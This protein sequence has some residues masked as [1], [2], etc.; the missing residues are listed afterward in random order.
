M[1]SYTQS[2]YQPALR[3]PQGAHAAVGY[4]EL[5][6]PTL[7]WTNGATLVTGG[8][9]A[10][11]PTDYTTPPE[12]T[13]DA[14]SRM[15][16]SSPVTVFDS[17]FQYGLAPLLYEQAL[18]GTASIT[19]NPTNS[20]AVLSGTTGG[21]ASA[22]LQSYRYVR[23]QPAKSHLA[24]ITFVL[25][26]ATAS[27]TKRVGLWDGSNGFYLEQ[28]GDGT[29]SLTRASTSSV[30]NQTVAQAS[31]NLDPLNGNGPSRIVLDLTKTQILVI[32]AQW[33]GVGRVRVGF[34]INGTV[35]YVHQFLHANVVSDAYTQTLNL[36]VR[37]S[38]VTTAGVAASMKM[39]CASVQSEGG[40]ESEVGYNFAVEAGGSAG[41]QSLAHLLSVQPATG[42]NGLVNRTVFMPES[43]DLVNT[44]SNTLYWALCIG[45]NI[46]GPFTSVNALS[47]T[48]V[49]IGGALTGLPGIVIA[50]GYLPATNQAKS[51]LSTAVSTKYPI[52]LN[53]A[54][55][56]RISG[57]LSLLVSGL[58]AAATCHGA[59]TWKEI[60]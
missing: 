55:V 47:A 17:T 30:G 46:G 32:D 42:Y 28:A 58:T 13:L 27:A 41:N 38:L 49:N 10:V 53:A 45:C 31:W 33:L 24:V 36:P 3:P 59:L 54:G 8:W 20:C 6:D 16:V 2:G 12:Y 37:A 22:V 43:V 44:D 26:P 7:V 25:G 9:R 18:T 56:P 11:M 4:N 23:Y 57:R 34:D 19:H 50:N 5:Y 1:I 52:T 48:D 15:R 39:L 35:Y 60:R 29:V 40:S 14:F 51:S 21:G